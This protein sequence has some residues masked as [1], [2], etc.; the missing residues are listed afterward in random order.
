MHHHMM[1]LPKQIFALKM[2]KEQLRQTAT[3][4]RQ[5]QGSFDKE[6]RGLIGFS[7]SQ[8][9]IYMFLGKQE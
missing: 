4:A 3:I 1:L 9:Y 6:T 5:Q 7:V 8:S 2:V